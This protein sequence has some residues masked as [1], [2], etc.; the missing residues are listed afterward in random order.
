MTIIC[1]T[2]VKQHNDHSYDKHSVKSETCTV[3]LPKQLESSN[4]LDSKI[5]NIMR[6][7]LLARA[8]SQLDISERVFLLEALNTGCVTVLANAIVDNQLVRNAVM[9]ICLKQ[10]SCAVSKLRCKSKEFV[11]VLSKKN[12]SD[13][14]TF[15]FDSIVNEIVDKCPLLMEIMVAMSITEK[16]LSTNNYQKLFPKWA[17]VYG[18]LM[19]SNFQELNLMQTI[20]TAIMEDSLCDQKVITNNYTLIFPKMLW[21]PI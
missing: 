20:V 10:L 2:G 6:R 16:D 12:I 21:Q 9:S 7:C 15:K 3:V 17:L 13:L 19:Q 14:K 5:M 11:S 4:E 1:Q 8:N 18:I